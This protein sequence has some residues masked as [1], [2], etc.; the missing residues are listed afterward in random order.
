M[1][2]GNEYIESYQIGLQQGH[3]VHQDWG[4]LRYDFG[5]RFP[6]EEVFSSAIKPF[7]LHNSLSKG[8]VYFVISDTSSGTSDVQPETAWFADDKLEK[9][10]IYRKHF[11]TTDDLTWI[12]PKETFP[13]Q[14]TIREKY[15]QL[16][17][18]V[19]Q[20]IALPKNWDSYGGN[21]INEDC[22]GRAIKILKHLVEVRDRTS[23][24]LPVPFVAPLSS[25]GIQIEWEKDE[26]YLELS[27]VPQD[28]DIE[29]F[30]SDKTC[31]GELTLEG[32]LKSVKNFEELF[33]WFIKGEA[34]DLGRLNF[35]SFFDESVT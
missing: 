8:T 19:G 12:S 29:Y 31:A 18:R 7:E 9:V 5:F 30:A 33:F 23:I 14:W 28:S 13:P 15:D 4:I 20:L 6:E 24:S 34:E 11:H 22:V 35:E 16:F 32:S 2:F 10:L 27:L 21:A 17:N 1:M 26:R 25:G 3:G